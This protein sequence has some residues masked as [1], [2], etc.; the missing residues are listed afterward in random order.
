MNITIQF[1]LSF[2]CQYKTEILLQHLNQTN[3]GNFD[4]G[5]LFLLLNVRE[6]DWF[7]VARR[8]KT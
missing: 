7:S 5:I 6:I 8:Q 1:S 4:V 3:I 2:S